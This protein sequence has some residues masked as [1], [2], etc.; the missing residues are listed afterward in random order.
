[1]DCIYAIALREPAK[2]VNHM[3]RS[4]K[5]DRASVSRPTGPAR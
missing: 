2:L 3:H 1:M 5:L 4:G